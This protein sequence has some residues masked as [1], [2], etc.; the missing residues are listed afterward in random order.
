MVTS[1]P[2]QI[3]FDPALTGLT[4]QVWAEPPGKPEGFRFTPKQDK[5]RDMLIA[6]AVH[7]ALGG[8]A[9]SGKTF[10]LCRQVIVRAMRSPESRHVIFRFRFNALWASIVLDTMPKVLRLCFPD[11]PSMDA[12]LNKKMGYMT[13]PN[14]AE[15][16]FAGLDDKDRTEKILGMEFATLY[17]NECSQIPWASVVL[18]R[19]RLA[20]NC[21]LNL[22]CF[23]DF[24]PPSKKHWTFQQFVDKRNPETHRPEANQHNYGFFFINPEDNKQNLAKGFIEEL[25]ALPPKARDRFL[26]GLFADDAEGALWT[27]ETLE[28]NRR[29]GRDREP[30]IPDYLRIVVAIDPSGCSGPEDTR[31]D[32]IGIIVVGL[33]TDGHAYLI[34]DLSGRYKPEE[35]GRIAVEA[36]IRHMADRIVGERNFGGDMV[37]AVVQ[38]AAAE[39]ARKEDSMLV[40]VAYDEVTASR[41][42]VVRAEPISTL[43]DLNLVHHI[44]YYPELEEQMCSM[45]VSGYVGLK[46]PD[47]CDALVWAITYLFPQM[48]KKPASTA[49]PVNVNTSQR[50]QQR[51]RIGQG[52]YGHNQPNVNTSARARARRRL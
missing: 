18:A 41:G 7:C 20:Q 47:R 30:E 29:T 22:K 2:L 11:L 1:D 19:T 42:K 48:T 26:L 38:S 21:G 31:S 40:P 24:N 23:Y 52:S 4:T 3:R 44:G 14:G 34:E 27:E 13:L 50:D 9:R 5:A 51:N 49:G 39:K 28:Q 25:E 36:Y 35:W 15:I 37:R 33:G 32:E 8:G 17:F 10:L 43:Y 12:M 46:S 6:D 16:W 45:L